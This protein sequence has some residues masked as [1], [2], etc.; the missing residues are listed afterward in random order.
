MKKFMALLMSLF[1]LLGVAGC[2][3]SSSNNTKSEKVAKAG[4]Y[5][6]KN[7][8]MI[9]PYSAGGGT[10]TDARTIAPFMEKELGCKIQVTNVTGGG[11]WVAW[12][13]LLTGK[14]DGMT[15]SVT[16]LPGILVGYLNP[17]M[18][19][20]YTMKNFTFLGNFVSDPSTIVMNKDEKRFKDMKSLIEY[21]KTHVVTFG[22]TGSGTDEGVLMYRLNAEFGTK[23][24]EVPVKGAA[25]NMAA[26]Q[27][28]HIDVTGLN[29][30]EVKKLHDNKQVVVLAVF[31][32]K[33]NPLLKGVPA[34]NSLKLTSKS[35]VNNSSRGFAVKA[36]T[37]DN[38]VKELE[39]ALKKAATNPEV[40]KKMASYGS[41]ADYMDAQADTKM[42]AENETLLKGMADL[43]GWTK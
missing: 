5:K 29:V 4:Y 23:F 18:N 22:T 31:S 40:V 38:A 13:K 42:I 15:I 19:R 32:A 14:N 17:K 12:Q 3:G 26:I 1:L 24:K 37:P 36:G 9:V 2:G 20:K 7:V 16:N 43:L 35:I 30:S 34:F 10:D 28:G 41:S 25:Q 27:G 6:G 8:T 33:E 39:A 21:A 11:G